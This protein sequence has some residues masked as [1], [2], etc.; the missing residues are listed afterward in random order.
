[1]K[2]IIITEV[3]IIDEDELKDNIP[4]IIMKRKAIIDIDKINIAYDVDL[5]FVNSEESKKVKCVYAVM[6]NGQDIYINMSLDELY[7][8]MSNGSGDI[9]GSNNNNFSTDD[10][11][12]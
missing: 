10:K 1:M 8:L 9:Y 5:I 11:N 2:N 3:Y 7:M 4:N 12:F 6:D